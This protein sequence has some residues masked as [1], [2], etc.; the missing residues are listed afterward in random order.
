MEFGDV[1]S[2]ILVI[3]LFILTINFLMMKDLYAT[4]QKK[5]MIPETKKIYFKDDEIEKRNLRDE[6]FYRYFNP[7]SC[8]SLTRYRA[9]LNCHY[10]INKLKGQ[11]KKDMQAKIDSMVENHNQFQ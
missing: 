5:T 10:E 6:I 4:I 8:N 1:Y 7:Y 3:L 2:L 11:E 9:M